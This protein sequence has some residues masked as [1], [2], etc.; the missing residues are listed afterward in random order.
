MYS[1]LGKFQFESKKKIQENKQ[2]LTRKRTLHVFRLLVEIRPA[3]I[4]N[5][6]FHRLVSK[7]DFGQT[8]TKP[9]YFIISVQNYRTRIQHCKNVDLDVFLDID[10]KFVLL[11]TFSFS[12]Q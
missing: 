4:Y 6:V 5:L 7:R 8:L 10:L 11:I 9:K 12:F 2:T 1:K 3:R